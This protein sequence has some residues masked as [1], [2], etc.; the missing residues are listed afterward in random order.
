MKGQLIVTTPAEY[1]ATVDDKHRS[2]I[3]ALDALIRA[4][5]DLGRSS[6]AACSATGRSTTLLRAA[7]R[8]RLQAL[9]R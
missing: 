9:D 4:Y 3:A 6:W 7:A 2:D 1:I 5:T 8:A